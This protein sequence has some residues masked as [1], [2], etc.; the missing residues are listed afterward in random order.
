MPMK[1]L[2]PIT[3]PRPRDDWRNP[4]PFAPTRKTSLAKMVSMAL[5]KPNTEDTAS[6]IMTPRMT[7]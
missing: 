6:M 3:A 7:G 2:E 1:K 5:S 4:N